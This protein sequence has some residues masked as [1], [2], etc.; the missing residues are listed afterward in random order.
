MLKGRLSPQSNY[1]SVTA[2]R[3]M[4]D[5]YST[6]LDY[7]AERTTL[8][9]LNAFFSNLVKMR[10]KIKSTEDALIFTRI[11]MMLF[12]CKNRNQNFTPKTGQLVFLVN[13]KLHKLLN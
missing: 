7:R 3:N 8:E 12:F 6:D 11:F 5:F 2:A 13:Q 10:Q 1:E 4:I 9:T